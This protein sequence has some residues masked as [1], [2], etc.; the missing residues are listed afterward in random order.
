MPGVGL[1]TVATSP[2]AD[3]AEVGSVSFGNEDEA[4]DEPLCRPDGDQC[5]ELESMEWQQLR[6]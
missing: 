4:P 1:K 2:A 3:L 6:P 5:E